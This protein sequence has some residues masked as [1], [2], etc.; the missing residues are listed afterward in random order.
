MKGAAEFKK[1]YSY[2]DDP[3]FLVL[4]I[5]CRGKSGSCVR[6]LTSALRTYRKEKDAASSDIFPDCTHASAADKEF[7]DLLGTPSARER[8]HFSFE[9]F[10]LYDHSEDF[11]ILSKNFT[12]TYES[13]TVTSQ[14]RENSICEGLMKTCSIT[15]LSL[16]HLSLIAELTFSMLKSIEG[17]KHMSNATSTATLHY[18]QNTLHSFRSA[19]RQL[20]SHWKKPSDASATQAQVQLDVRQLCE[21]ILP[22]YS[23]EKMVGI[24]SK[25]ELRGTVKKGEEGLAISSRA[26][27]LA[28][29]TRAKTSTFDWT[30]FAVTRR[31]LPTHQMSKLAKLSKVTDGQRRLDVILD[32]RF[33]GQVTATRSFWSTMSEF[34]KN[35]GERMDD[36]IKRCSPI[37]HSALSGFIGR[38]PGTGMTWRVAT[39]NPSGAGTSTLHYAVNRTPTVN[40]TSVLVAASSPLLRPNYA[41]TTVPKNEKKMPAGE[42]R[43]FRRRVITGLLGAL[44]DPVD[45]SKPSQTKAEKVSKTQAKLP[46]GYGT[47]RLYGTSKTCPRCQFPHVGGLTCFLSD[48]ELEETFFLLLGTRSDSLQVI[49]EVSLVQGE[50]DIRKGNESSEA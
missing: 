46:D 38:A 13:D 1:M 27:A 39:P 33:E 24:P 47:S 14:F 11:A 12:S 25:E 41:I 45:L 2:L 4:F 22:M 9:L 28:E 7:V 17:G 49:G 42:V 29:G 40:S 10:G 26:L 36:E 30:A 44:F 21:Q 31:E 35:L 6:A 34:N 37:V 50:V 23:E 15:I 19:R 5:F 43:K 20:I 8:A 32:R 16:P 18:V 48:K 3:F